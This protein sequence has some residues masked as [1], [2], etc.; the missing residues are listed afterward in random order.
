MKLFKSISF[1]LLSIVF[2]HCGNELEKR[3]SSSFN[4]EDLR[5]LQS[6]LAPFLDSI[7]KKEELEVSHYRAK[8]RRADSFRMEMILQ[9]VLLRVKENSNKKEYHLNYDDYSDSS[10]VINVNVKLGKLF[11]QKL[12]HV[13][14]RCTTEIGIDHFN[15]YV[16]TGN[17]V[18][19]VLHHEEMHLA[20]LSDSIYDVNEDYRKDFVINSYGTTGCCLKAF[21]DVY[22][23]EA[24]EESFSDH[25]NFIN[26]T[27]SPKEKLIRGVC[28]G[29]LGETEMYKYKWNR[30]K[31]DT[32]EY[33]SYQKDKDGKKTGKIIISD[34][35][36]YTKA[37]KGKKVIDDVPNDYKNI[38]GFD[39]FTGNL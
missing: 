7:K 29:H 20:Y 22:L 10:Y 32:L 18:K 21:S 12:R 15:I 16:I 34:T 30:T 9:E 1:I 19:K 35:R 24:N 36:N 38:Y 5:E 39:W 25:F 28:Y 33:V 23:L 26:P 11:T 8:E 3:N 2:C 31:V 4:E 27:F 14:I 13:I 37:K 6:K 17:E